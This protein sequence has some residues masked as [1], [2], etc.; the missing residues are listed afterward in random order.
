MYKIKVIS[1]AE[2]LKQVVNIVSVSV[3]I[4]QILQKVCNLRIVQKWIWNVNN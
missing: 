3:Q 2:M 4:I 1:G